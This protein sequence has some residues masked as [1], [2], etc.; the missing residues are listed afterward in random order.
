VCPETTAKIVDAD[1]P[2]RRPNSAL[3]KLPLAN[4]RLI[5]PAAS[6]VSF[7]RRTRAG[8]FAALSSLFCF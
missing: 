3:E 4:S 2:N 1:T 5:S 6:G 8:V 7:S